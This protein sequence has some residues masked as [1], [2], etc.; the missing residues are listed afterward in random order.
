MKIL[1]DENIPLVTVHALRDLRHDVIDIRGTTDQGITDEELWR[2]AQSQNCLLITTDKGFAGYREEAHWGLLIVRLRQ[3]TR[4]KI[5]NRVIQALTEYP[6]EK[7]P[8]LMV[9]IRDAVQSCWVS[10]PA[11]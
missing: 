5:H 4:L 6:P 1:V 8:G 11:K 2:K 7:W 9:V 3:P 10:R